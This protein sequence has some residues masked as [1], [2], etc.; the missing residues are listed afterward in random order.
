[1]ERFTAVETARVVSHL[2]NFFRKAMTQLIQEELHKELNTWEQVDID[3]VLPNPDPLKLNY[4][5]FTGVTGALGIYIVRELLTHTNAEIY[6][7]VR[8]E[9]PQEA[10]ERIAAN[11]ACYNLACTEQEWTRLHF[12]IGDLHQEQF[13]LTMSD[14]GHLADVIDTIIHCAANTSFVVR[15]EVSYK[16]NVFGT[17]ELLRFAIRQR[18]KAFHHV[19]SCGVGVLAYYEHGDKDLGLFNGYSQSKYVSEKMVH[20]MLVRGLPGTIYEIGYLSLDYD[21]FNPTDSFESFLQLCIEL[22]LVPEID[23]DFD[24]TPITSVAREMVQTA[25]QQNFQQHKLNLHHPVPLP[26]SRIVASVC[27]VKPD[28]KPMPF[29]EFFPIFQE[30][31]RLYRGKRIYAMKK[32]I[33]KDFPLQ[34]NAMFRGVPSDFSPAN[35]P[36]KYDFERLTSIFSHVQH[37]YEWQ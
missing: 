28:V 31:M 15:Y 8:A 5:L 3:Q 35:S 27:A 20:F 32:V 22:K 33:S 1:M 7:L 11:F 6:C 9:A 36:Q 37:T 4:V 30:F 12:V 19:S 13:G 10:K 34:L 29:L 21:R 26:W 24:Y 18:I 23:A 25:L 2:P 17:G 14:Y 16:T